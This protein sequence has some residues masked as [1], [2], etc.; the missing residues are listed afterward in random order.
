MDLNHLHTVFETVALPDE[1]MYIKYCKYLKVR[2][3]RIELPMDQMYQ[4][5]RLV[6]DILANT[7]G[8][9]KVKFKDT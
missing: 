9:L 6:S 4:F 7:D 3:D 8:T 2:A 1:L 5:Y